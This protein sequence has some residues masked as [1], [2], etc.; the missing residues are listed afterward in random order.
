MF[1]LKLLL[2]LTFGVTIATASAALLIS[3]LA[4]ADV[5]YTFAAFTGPGTPPTDPY[6]T[7]NLH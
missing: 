4:L 5:T 7:V 2:L 6:G 1:R 3:S